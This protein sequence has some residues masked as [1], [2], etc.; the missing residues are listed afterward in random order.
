MVRSYC[1]EALADC[2]KLASIVRVLRDVEKS[3]DYKSKHCPSR[4]PLPREILASP[5]P[6]HLQADSSELAL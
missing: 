5:F 2:L 6:S 1:D 4:R 3:Y